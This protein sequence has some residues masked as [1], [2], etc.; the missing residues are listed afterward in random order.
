MNSRIQ[1][2]SRRGVIKVAAAAAAIASAGPLTPAWAQSESKHVFFLPFDLI[3]EFVFELNAL[4]GGHFKAQGLDIEILNARGTSIAV[5]Q[6]VAGRASFSEMGALDMMKANAS[7]S[8]QMI[9]IATVAQAGIFDMVSLNSA[10]IRTPADMR[11]KTIGVLSI[12]GGTENMLDLTLASANIPAKDVPRQVIG[13]GMGAVEVLRQGRVQGFIT[14]SETVV[15]MKRANAPIDHW[16]V[17]KFA[18]LPGQVYV[19]TKKFMDQNPRLITRFLRALKASHEE[20]LSADPNMILDRVEKRF[21]LVGG[22]D[23]G[24]MVDALKL[25][26]QLNMAQGRQN[27]LRNVPALWKQ[28][29]DLAAKAGLMRLNAESLYTN[30][31]I[32]EAYS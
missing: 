12:G 25:H 22:K 14:T 4:V 3:A 29:T 19:V 21:E 23:R 16:N 32:N 1:N 10:P 31:F 20:I 7:Q 17:E 24:Y 6:L 26:I 11:G 30:Q 2:P 9:S 27:L 8:E 13:G 15:A 28:G 5:Q 18:P